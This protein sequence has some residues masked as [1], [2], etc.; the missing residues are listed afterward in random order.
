MICH[1]SSASDEMC[2]ALVAVSFLSLVR[3][4]ERD[5]TK[6]KASLVTSSADFKVL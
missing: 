5:F 1:R 3:N 2:S 4:F 6:I